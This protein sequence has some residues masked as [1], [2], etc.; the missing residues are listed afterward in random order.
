MI[1][2]SAELIVDGFQVHRRVGLSIFVL[3]VQHLVLPGDDLLGGDV[4]HLELAKV[5]QQLGADDVILGGPGVFLEPGFHVCRIEVHEA[6][7]G[8]IQI[9]GGFVE[10]FPFPCL[11]LPLG[12]ETP[13]LG[14]FALAVPAGIAVDRSPGV[15]LFF[16]I[17]CHQ[18][19]LLSFS[20]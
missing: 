18:L 3:V 7:E 8:H 13:L 2:N 15:G 6:L 20:P 11:R 17:D 1:E 12:L 16:L 4:A 14:L 9:G 5:G 19:P 10:L